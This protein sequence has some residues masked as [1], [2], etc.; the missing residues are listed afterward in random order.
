MNRCPWCGTDELYVKYHDE[1]WGVPVHDD[2]KHFEFLVLESAQAGLS[3]ITVLRKRENYRKAYKNFD[4]AKIALY[5]ENK[6]NE[7]MQNAGIIRNRRKIEASINNAK[8][9][10]NIQKEFGSFDKYIWG[11]VNNEP[12]V[13]HWHDISEVPATSEISDKVSKDL[14]SRG[15]KFL[16]S[17]IIYA[18]LQA[19]GVINDHLISCFKHNVL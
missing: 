9:F 14:K 1:E 15:F 10:L 3:W 7:L 6:I 11:F 13:N 18:H 19:T 5:D 8:G 17:T 16:G 2:K 12:I 4:A